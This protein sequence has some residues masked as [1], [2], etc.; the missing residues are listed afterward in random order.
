MTFE[1]ELVI[2]TI[3]L[4]WGWT[5][6][7]LRSP[8][9]PY[10]WQEGTHS[11]QRSLALV[12]VWIHWQQDDL[13][14]NNIIWNLG[15]LLI[16]SSEK[17]IITISNFVSLSF[18]AIQ[19]YKPCL[20]VK[21]QIFECLLD[22]HPLMSV[23]IEWKEAAWCNNWVDN[24]KNNTFFLTRFTGLDFLQLSMLAESVDFLVAYT[25]PKWRNEQ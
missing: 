23:I 16:F 6:E 4:V 19:L 25:V 3:T 8:S 10:L 20:S 12:W 22:L 18:G 17:E 7:S 24:N 1:Y 21:F 15:L 11:V 13:N 14:L 5:V 9:N 2:T